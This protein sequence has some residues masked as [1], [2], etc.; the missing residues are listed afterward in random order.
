[1]PIASLLDR[2]LDESGFEAAVLAEPMGRR[3]RANVRKLVE[4]PPPGQTLLF[5]PAADSGSQRCDVFL[6]RCMILH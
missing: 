4:R 6:H 1:M 2:A 5:D 3:K